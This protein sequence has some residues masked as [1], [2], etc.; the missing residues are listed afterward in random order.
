[1]NLGGVQLIC[2]NMVTSTRAIVNTARSMVS[3]IMKFLDSGPNKAVDS[4]LK[5]RILASEPD[6]AEGI[7]NFAPLGKT[8]VFSPMFLQVFILSYRI[9]AFLTAVS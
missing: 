9:H 4:T 5:T 8:A 7:H 3:T 1:M 2:N 6:N